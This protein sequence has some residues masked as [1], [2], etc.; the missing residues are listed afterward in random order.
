MDWHDFK[1]FLMYGVIV[2][3]IM[4]FLDPFW[5]VVILIGYPAYGFL[6]AIRK[7]RS[8]KKI[9]KAFDDTVSDLIKGIS[10]CHIFSRSPSLQIGRRKK[11]I[12]DVN[13]YNYKVYKLTIIKRYVIDST[14]VD[15]APSY[16]LVLSNN[17]TYHVL[18]SE[19]RNCEEG[20]IVWIV[21]TPTETMQA[22]YSEYGWY[23]LLRPIKLEEE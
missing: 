14:E 7:Y 20:Q 22:V 1:V 15:G 5:G 12:W 23:N 8:K 21:K 16:Y 9:E 18:E 4:M 6:Y 10:E 11:L 19:Y 3:T 13:H 17:T 2:G